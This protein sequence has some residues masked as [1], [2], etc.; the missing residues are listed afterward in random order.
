MSV[1]HKNRVELITFELS[2]LF[3]FITKKLSRQT[4]EREENK[5]RDEEGT[6][7]LLFYLGLKVLRILRTKSGSLPS[8]RALGFVLF[9]AVF[10]PVSGHQKLNEYLLNEL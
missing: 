2:I 3:F 10:L 4:L 1:F 6:S 5:R 8:M 7:L 9:T